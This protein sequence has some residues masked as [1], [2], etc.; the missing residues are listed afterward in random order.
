MENY[1]SNNYDHSQ[2]DLN[3]IEYLNELFNESVELYPELSPSDLD[4]LVMESL[5]ELSGYKE[6]KQTTDGDG[7]CWTK[8]RTNPEQ[9]ERTSF[10]VRYRPE[11]EVWSF[12]YRRL[13][14]NIIDSDRQ[15]ASLLS[16]YVF[17]WNEQHILKSSLVEQSCPEHTLQDVEKVSDLIACNFVDSDELGQD[18][19]DELEMLRD[20]ALVTPRNEAST[21]RLDA[22]DTIID[23]IKSA[24]GIESSGWVDDGKLHELLYRNLSKLHDEVIENRKAEEDAA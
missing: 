3:E 22:I 6:S 12:K 7:I 21:I 20:P 9:Y 1:N 17:I 13:D 16:E 14:S 11:T 8:T 18:L 19:Y 24:R 5:D 4:R 15:W 2:A 10:V 23:Q